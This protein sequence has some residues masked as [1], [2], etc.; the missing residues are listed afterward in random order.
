LVSTLP[1]KGKGSMTNSSMPIRILVVDD[2]PLLRE[3]IESLVGRQ[4]DMTVV[5]EASTGKEAI[6]LFR[7]HRP[8]VTLMDIR[9]PDLSGVDTMTEILRDFPEAKFIVVSTYNGDVQILRALKAGAKAYL[10]KSLLRKELLDTIRTVYGGRKRI[11]PEIAA[12]IANHV[13]EGNLT[14]REMDVLQLIAAGNPNKLV[15]DRLVVTEDTVKA[16]VKKI[17]YKLRANDRTHA[18]TI[19]IKRGIIDL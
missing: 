10:L 17:L 9:M 6:D 1:K 7:K 4:A 19:A 13:G 3:G 12:L 11:T 8:D 2:H 15:A 14:E 16:H 5:A 18:V